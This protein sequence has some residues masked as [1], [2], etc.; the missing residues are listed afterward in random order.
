MEIAVT[1]QSATH[2]VVSPQASIG[3]SLEASPE[4]MNLLSGSLYKNPTYAMVREVMC[5]AHD[6]HIEAG[7]P[8]TP[9]MVSLDDE[10]LTIR[11]FGHGI[12]KDQMG[13]I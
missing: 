5:N 1:N 4:L 11:D 9:I 8:D 10:Y 6:A 13:E 7:I 3:V 2:L 12:P